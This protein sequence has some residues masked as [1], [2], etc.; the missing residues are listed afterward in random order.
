[1]W[2][3]SIYEYFVSKP[4]VNP[5]R[6]CW[7]C[8]YWGKEEDYELLHWDDKLFGVNKRDSTPKNG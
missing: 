8:K 2:T 6:K 7:K 4:S 5:W 3:Q 1:M